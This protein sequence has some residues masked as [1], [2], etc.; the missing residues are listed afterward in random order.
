MIAAVIA[1]A[2][3]CIVTISMPFVFV[4]GDMVTEKIN[5]KGFVWKGILRIR[6]A[7]ACQVA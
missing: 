4:E 6:C 7:G 1:A 2:R 3:S 5:R